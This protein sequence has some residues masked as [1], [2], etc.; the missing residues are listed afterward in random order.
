MKFKD[1]YQAGQL[2]AQELLNY[3]DENGIVLGIPRGG[4]VVGYPIATTL[5]FPLDIILSK[6]IGHPMNQE[7]AIGAVSLQDLFINTPYHIPQR[8]IDMETI[9]IREQLKKRYEEYVGDKEPFDLKGKTV[10]IV[11]DGIATGNTVFATI[12]LVRNNFP[13]KI[14]LAVPVAPPAVIDRLEPLV[15]DIVCLQTPEPFGAVGYFYENF[16][17]VTDEEVIELLNDGIVKGGA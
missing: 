8:Y 5:D 15:E 4:V 3:R 11:D 9:R 13:D 16:E 6:K 7:L 10:I 2:L 12:G 17:Q 14:I 1:R